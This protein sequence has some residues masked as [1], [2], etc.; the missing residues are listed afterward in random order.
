VTP[1]SATPWNDIPIAGGACRHP[2][3]K[4]LPLFFPVKA[5][6]QDNHGAAAKAICAGCPIRTACLLGALDR[7]EEDGIWGGAGE[8]T[9]RTLRRAQAQGDDELAA[10]LAAHFRRLDG[11]PAEGDADL[12]AGFGSGA[13]HGNP[14]TYAKGCRCEPCCLAVAGRTAAS[15]LRPRRKKPA[16][17]P[18][19]TAPTPGDAP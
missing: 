15:K 10:V 1:F 8:Q 5:A 16:T 6:G 9:R 13:T 2:E 14:A 11:T 17:A 12:L 7:N 3:S 19:A 18:P 4:L